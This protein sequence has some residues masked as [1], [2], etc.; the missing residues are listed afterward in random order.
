MK[1]NE[2]LE[3][4][5]KSWARTKI[6]SEVSKTKYNE[7]RFLQ[8]TSQNISLEGGGGGGGFLGGIAW[9]TERMEEKIS[10]RQRSIEGACRSWLLIRGIR[11]ILQSFMG[12]S[13]S[14]Y[15][16]TPP[17]PPPPQLPGD[18]WWLAA[19]ALVTTLGFFFWLT[20]ELN[21][22]LSS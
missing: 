9:F 7:E 11:R 19:F 18:K 13:L 6:L 16:L 21:L 22:L 12:G 14:P 3:R 20:N 10:R 8:G 17:F 4:G 15:P 1:C 5:R 2:N